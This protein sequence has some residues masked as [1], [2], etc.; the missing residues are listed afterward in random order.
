MKI[1]AARVEAF[2]GRPDPAAAAV[3][4][5]GP[6]GGLVRERAQ[7][8]AKT[9]V[10]D[11]D[12]PF[13]MVEL[14]PAAL[15]ADP[16]RLADEAA[17]IPFTGGRQLVRLREAGDGVSEVLRRFLA[18]PPAG[19]EGVALVLAE[20]GELG[21]RSPLR[22]LFEEARNAAAIACYKDE[23][24]ELA[25][26]IKST[27]AAGGVSLTS[28]ALDYLV[29]HLGGDR[30]VTR[31]ELEKLAVYAGN[32]GEIGIED[33]VLCVG[34]SSALRLDDVAFA[35]GAGDPAALERALERVLLEGVAPVTVLRAVA[36]HFQRLHLAAS[37]LAGGDSAE[38]AMAALR[39]PVFFKDRPS[40]R[41]QTASWPPAR[42]AEALDLLTRAEID[43]KRTAMPAELLCRRA[44][45]SVTGRA[46]RAA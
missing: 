2:L 23:G 10:G 42:A 33:A 27:L 44:L 11:L 13:R 7:R 6:D 17:A 26:L 22:R 15:A 32:G 38:A 16:A 46:R 20:A 31:S 21:P 34:D 36:R 9:V 29:D 45:L 3:L 41:A 39:P 5:Y 18:D 28:E 4:L 25:R 1:A 24:A 35:A 14:S 40:F 8:L 37:R 19:G 30:M 43:C 12:D